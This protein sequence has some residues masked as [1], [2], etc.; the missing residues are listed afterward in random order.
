MDGAAK[1]LVSLLESD[2][3]KIVCK[4]QFDDDCDDATD[5]S[6]SLLES[7]IELT[8]LSSNNIEDTA[9]SAAASTIISMIESITIIT[10]EQKNMFL[11]L[12]VTIKSTVLVYISQISLVE[13]NK[14]K[15]SGA[16]SFP[17][18]ETTID[19]VDEN[20]ARRSK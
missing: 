4:D 16:L 7:T 20:E 19:Q 9:I 3:V 10:F 17:G 11:S 14:L 1:S 18:A 2:T 12:I 13:S 15:I 8:K 6:K 5:D